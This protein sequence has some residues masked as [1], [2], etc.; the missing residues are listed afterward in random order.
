MKNLIKSVI[1]EHELTVS[2]F[3]SDLKK[4]KDL[5][6]WQYNKM[7]TKGQKKNGFKSIA[8]HKQAL[9]TRYK[10]EQAKKCTAKV[11]KINTIIKA[12]TFESIKISVEWKKSRMWGMNPNAKAFIQTKEQT[13]YTTYSGSIGGCGYDKLSTAIARCLNQSKELLKLLYA[14]KNRNVEANNVELFGYGSGYGLLPYFEGGVGVSCYPK[15]FESIGYEF[16][17]VA[18]GK[19]FD[20]YEI[21]KAKNNRKKQTKYLTI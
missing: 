13:G 5:D 20:V 18:T 2:E 4:A 1:K 14:K 12:G 19:T 21:T 16:R 6:T 8:D 3:I 7:L 9:E 17:T 11:E 15:I 10:K